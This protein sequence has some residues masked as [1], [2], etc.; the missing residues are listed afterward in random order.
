[1]APLKP[2]IEEA[3]GQFTDWQGRATVHS[4]EAIASNGL[5]TEEIMA[6]VRRHSG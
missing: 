6:I 4:G 2:I 1:V 3:G 5:V